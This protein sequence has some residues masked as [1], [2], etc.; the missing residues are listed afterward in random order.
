MN[1]KGIIPFVSDNQE[2]FVEYLRCA[3]DNNIAIITQILNSE[4]IEAGAK[5]IGNLFNQY[6]NLIRNTVV[7]NR[8]DVLEG[9]LKYILSCFATVTILTLQKYLSQ[10]S[11]MEISIYLM[12]SHTR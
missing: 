6:E 5:T 3:L 4:N 10:S 11:L 7:Y 2:E 1:I 12:R 9:I 8:F